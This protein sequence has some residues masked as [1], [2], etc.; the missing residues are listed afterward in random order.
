MRFEHNAKP[1]R[2]EHEH[3]EAGH[4]RAMRR[5]DR[6]VTDAARIGEI[7]ARCDIVHVAYEDA[8]GLAVVP[9]NLAYE[10]DAETRALTLWFHSAPRGRKMDAM[11][12]AGNALPVAFAMETD[13]EVTEGRTLC[14]WGEAFASVAGTGVASLVDDDDLETRCKALA[15]LMAHAAHIDH[16]EFTDAQVR[17]V[18]IWKVAVDH[19]TC[20]VRPKPSPV[21]MRSET[22]M[23]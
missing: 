20:K 16:A 10:Y 9:L 13:C 19:L 17:A 15:L 7:I 14:N 21:H 22:P 4:H 12:A 23:E 18:A 6:E 1:A 2:R 3:T 5:A 8:E 11:R